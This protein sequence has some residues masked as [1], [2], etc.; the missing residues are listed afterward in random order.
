MHFLKTIASGKEDEVLVVEYRKTGDLTV[1]AE[2]YQRYMELL[3]GV[4]LKYLKEPEDAKDAVLSLYEE[5][6][7]KLRKHEVANFRGWLY[8]VTRNHCLM[9]LRSQKSK[10]R[11]AGS[12]IMQLEEIAHH[13]EDGNNEEDFKILAECMEQLNIGQRE[14]IELFYL[15]EKCYKEI[16]TVTGKDI[17]TIRSFIQNGRR[18]LKLCMENRA[19]AS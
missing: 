15:Q 5:L 2:L 18:N 1:L 10:P 4:C 3:Y 6:I 19:N 9:K 11:I 13:N 12:D 7:L 8:Q 17:N 14:V 16:A